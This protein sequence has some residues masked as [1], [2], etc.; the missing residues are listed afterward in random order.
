MPNECPFKA[1]IL[2]DVA[3]YKQ[4]KEEEK[5]KQKE[6]WKAEAEAKPEKKSDGLDDLVASAAARQ[7]LHSQLNTE[8]MEDDQ[9]KGK[10]D[11]SAKAYYKEFKKVG[12]LI[13]L[14]SSRVKVEEWL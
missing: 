6:I 10:P 8:P 5:A 1:E 13:T 11:G 2:Q 12:K 9:L 7:S 14:T 4:H 3:N